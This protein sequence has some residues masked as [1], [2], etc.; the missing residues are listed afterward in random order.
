MTSSL[1][2]DGYYGRSVRF[3]ECRWEVTSQMPLKVIN[4]VM[5]PPLCQHPSRC[6]AGSLQ[7]SLHLSNSYPSSM[8]WHPCLLDLS[9]FGLW[10]SA[11]VRVNTETT[12]ESGVSGHGGWSTAEGISQYF[13]FSLHSFFPQSGAQ[14]S[15]VSRYEEKPG[16]CPFFKS[17]SAFARLSDDG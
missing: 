1:R 12:N 11:P 13:L 7:G 8:V 10:Q 15:P 17:G 4:T 6:S 9:L 3:K 5:S 2:W 16:K 14:S